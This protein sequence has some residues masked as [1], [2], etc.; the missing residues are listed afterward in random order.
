MLRKMSL[1]NNFRRS[2]PY[3]HSYWRSGDLQGDGTPPY[4]KNLT[5]PPSICG[6][7]NSGG[8]RGA[9][10]PRVTLLSPLYLRKKL[11][12]TDPLLPLFP[13]KIQSVLQKWL[14]RVTLY[15]IKFV[16]AR[17][18]L[19]FI[20]PSSRVLIQGLLQD[21]QESSCQNF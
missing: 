14:V 13:C 8:E 5:P 11:P 9:L 7:Q 16:T 4:R 2:L 21:G 1:K 17:P 6:R 20:P 12:L 3:Y 15:S 19:G 18:I 10:L